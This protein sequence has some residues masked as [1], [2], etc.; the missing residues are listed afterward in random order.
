MYIY[1]AIST[2]L[3]NQLGI[4]SVVSNPHVAPLPPGAPSREV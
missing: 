3:R 1:L 4:V 2:I